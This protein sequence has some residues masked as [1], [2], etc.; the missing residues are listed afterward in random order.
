LARPRLARPRLEHRTR[1]P[2]LAGLVLR[3][4]NIYAPRRSPEVR[5]VPAEVIGAAVQIPSDFGPPTEAATH[6]NSRVSIPSSDY[7]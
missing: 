6:E 2:P 3:L 1:H 4:G 5:G 7:S